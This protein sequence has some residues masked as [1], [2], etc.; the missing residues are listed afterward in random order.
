MGL[1]NRAA[2][3]IAVPGLPQQVCRIIAAAEGAHDASST[4]P[5]SRR[6]FLGA[7]GLGGL[8]DV[9]G[10][11]RAR[12]AAQAPASAATLDRSVV[13]VPM[14]CRRS[15]RS[16]ELDYAGEGARRGEVD[17]RREDLPA[18]PRVRGGDAAVWHAQLLADDSGGADRRAVR[19]QQAG[20]PR[21]VRDRADRPGRHAV[22]RLRAHRHPAGQRRRPHRNALLQRVQ[23]TGDRVLRRPAEAGHRA[24]QAAGHA[25]PPGGRCRFEG[26]HAEPGGGDHAGRS[27]RGPVTT[28]HA[29]RRH[30]AGRRDPVSHRLG[31]ALDEGQREVQRR[32]ARAGPGGR[33][34]GRRAR[35][36]PDGRGLRRRSRSCRTRIPRS[37]TPSTA[38]CSR[39]TGSST[40]RT[41]S[42]TS[43]LPTASTSSCTCSCPCPSKARRVRPAARLRLPR[44]TRRIGGERR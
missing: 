39:K 7:L 38:S 17:S 43:C 1:R 19:G 9:L 15:G 22:R 25:R 32:R 30:P 24:H 26:A 6:R 12:L 14:G 34:V 42:S 11:R 2:V 23:R 5:S 13:A 18:W 44:G 3:T 28:G 33:P 27:S 20:L 37:P 41:W 4:S 8:L 16:V 36:L 10:A 21:R 29:G 31:P 40:T 35:S